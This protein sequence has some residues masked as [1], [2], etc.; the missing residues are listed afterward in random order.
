MSALPK[1]GIDSDPTAF[2][3][4]AAGGEVWFVEGPGERCG[5]IFISREAALAFIR[6]ERRVM[7][8]TSRHARFRPRPDAEAP[9]PASLRLVHG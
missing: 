6:R 1:A 9:P 3:L 7:E 2:N 8:E 4:R 5:G